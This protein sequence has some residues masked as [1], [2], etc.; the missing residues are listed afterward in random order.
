[1]VEHMELLRMDYQ[2]FAERYLAEGRDQPARECRREADRW[3]R[4]QRRFERRVQR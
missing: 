2:A 4:R 1:M 3:E